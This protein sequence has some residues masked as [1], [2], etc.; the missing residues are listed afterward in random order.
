MLLIYI[1]IYRKKDFFFFFKWNESLKEA[2]DQ[3]QNLKKMDYC[4]AHEENRGPSTSRR[5]MVSGKEGYRDE[6]GY[7]EG[8]NRHDND[9]S[10]RMVQGNFEKYIFF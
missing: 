6:Y 5:P 7:A 10:N 9:K 3:H 4:E 2:E 8:G 1:Y